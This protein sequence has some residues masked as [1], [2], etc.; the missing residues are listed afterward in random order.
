[1]QV[2]AVLPRTAVL[3]GGAAQREVLQD[4]L[5]H[6]LARSGQGDR[7]AVV[8]DERLARRVSPLDV[9]LLGRGVCGPRVDRS[10]T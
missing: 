8:L 3:G 6:A 9:R 7:A 4:T 10:P 5:I 2:E 1:M